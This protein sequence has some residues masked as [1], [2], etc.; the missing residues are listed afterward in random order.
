ML[1]EARAIVDISI[2]MDASKRPRD[3]LSFD[4][5]SLRASD[6][7]YSF[8]R[9]PLSA[10][11]EA[12]VSEQPSQGWPLLKI[13]QS[14]TVF[15]AV[16]GILNGAFTIAEIAIGFGD[17]GEHPLVPRGKRRDATNLAVSDRLCV[18]EGGA[19]H[20]SFSRCV[21]VVPRNS[22]TGCRPDATPRGHPRREVS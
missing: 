15:E 18:L 16:L 9:L 6:G 3:A 19:Y 13:R 14:V 21:R 1:A 5:A 2:E 20:A 12:W 10:G 22:N 7:R 8:R 17:I 4:G 11:L